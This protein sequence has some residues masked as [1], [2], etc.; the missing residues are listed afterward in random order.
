MGKN[1]PLSRYLGNPKELFPTGRYFFKQAK[2]VKYL[3]II[4]HGKCKMFN[5]KLWVKEIY[6]VLMKNQHLKKKERTK[7]LNRLKEY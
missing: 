6:I 4:S 2:Y 1:K 3:N 7:E 5:Q